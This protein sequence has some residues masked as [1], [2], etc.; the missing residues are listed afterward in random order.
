LSARTRVLSLLLAALVLS[1]MAASLVL[2][3]GA[4]LTIASDLIQC[5]LFLVAT[6]A[7][8]LN[9]SPSRSPLPRT[10]VFWILMT[11]GMLFWFAYQLMWSYF[12]VIRRQ[13]VPDPFLGD[14][15][16]FLHLVPM[17][18][19]L[20]IFPHLHDDGQAFRIRT[21]D[22]VLLISWWVFIYVYTVIPWQAVVVDSASYDKN[23]NVAY[24]TEKLALLLSLSA[25]AYTARGGWRSL[26]GQLVGSCGL[27]AASSYVANWALSHKLYYSGGVYDIPLILSIAWIAAVALFADRWDLSESKPSQPILGVWI[28]RL[29]MVAIFS[30]PWFALWAL[31]K[32]PTPF[33]VRRFRILLTLL[34][35][36]LMGSMVF[37]RQ[38]LLARELSMLLE[39]SRRSYDELKT[40]QAQL[41]ESEKLA[42]LGQL[43]GGAA[44]EINN[45]L[46][47]M[48]GY[49]EILSASLLPPYEQRLAAR[50]AEQVRHTKTLVASLLTF[51]HESPARITTLDTN[52]VL[53]T[54]ARLLKPQLDAQSITLDL[55]CAASLPPVAADSNQILHVCLH[56]AAQ[57]TSQF[58]PHSN[59][60]LLVRSRRQESTVVIDFCESSPSPDLTFQPLRVSEHS[61]RLASLSLSAC[62]RIA[63][64]HRGR[65]LT[66]SAVDGGRA[67]RLELPIADKNPSPSSASPFG[68]TN[69]ARMAPEN[70]T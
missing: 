1:Q 50:I 7:F 28:T 33:A 60:G 4:A 68:A 39:K 8:L 44:H 35:M 47:A 26:Y 69:P 67:F 59:P 42:S 48:L 22:L 45:P 61:K 41:I 55:V 17:M 6:V 43:V 2:A 36:V 12:E 21:L 20:A 5:S 49:S 29:G 24:L 70:G 9:T 64:E 63:E 38:S 14:V 62:C 34:T 37:L 23:L 58:S 56:L 10:R 3:Q 27:Y 30:L 11:G 13:D 46:T 15:V 18:A 32:D 25:L 57:V 19:A 16:L 40:L 53:Q 51:A 65:I 66:R 54:A 31:L 52:S